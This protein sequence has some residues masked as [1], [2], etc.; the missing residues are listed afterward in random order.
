MVIGIFGNNI[1]AKVAFLVLRARGVECRL[2]GKL[3]SDDEALLHRSRFASRTMAISIDNLETLRCIMDCE[4]L[5]E[6]SGVIERILVLNGQ[7]SKG[8]DVEL[9]ARD[10]G[11]DKMGYIIDYNGL[12]EEIDRAIDGKMVC[13]VRGIKRDGGGFIVERDGCSEGLDRI[14]LTDGMYDDI[15]DFDVSEG[16]VGY[17]YKEYGMTINVEHEFLHNNTAIEWFTRLGPLALLPMRDGKRSNIV[18]T[19][20]SDLARDVMELEGDKRNE[21][22][23]SYLTNL[24]SGYVGRI[25]IL[26][27]VSIF[28]LCV[29]YGRQS[30][31]D[32][33]CFIGTKSFIMHPI[34]GQG[35]NVILRDIE[36]LA[37]S[38]CKSGGFSDFKGSLKRKIDV[39]SMLFMTHNL[40]Q[41]FK[42]SN[43]IISGVR[44]LGMG[45]FN[46]IDFLKRA[47]VN[48]A[49]G[50]GFFNGGKGV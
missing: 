43:P 33:I 17:D 18:R 12:C 26:G 2:F 48:N 13:D 11:Y 39:L 15:C 5:F 29:G 32:G 6:K 34:A 4:S 19:I 21:F 46:N 41:F 50:T 9:R 14:I 47:C 36:R 31:D 42:I 45:I 27:D 28:P 30:K 23:L 44:R 10:F 40:N 3:Y 24:L 7:D 1:T 35:F 25:E 49:I 16:R 37:E 38:I 8:H 20:P 22:I